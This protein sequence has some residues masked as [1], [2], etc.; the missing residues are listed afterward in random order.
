MFCGKLVYLIAIE[1]NTR[2]TYGEVTN[3]SIAGMEK[4]SVADTKKATSFLRAFQ[5]IIDQ[6]MN[7]KHLI[8]D[9]ESAFKSY[10]AKSYYADHGIEFHPVERQ[11]ENYIPKLMDTEIPEKRKRHLTTIQVYHSLTELLTQSE[12]WYINC[13]SD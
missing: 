2:F 9:G 12:T 10:L 4:F 8:G 1:V 13:K 3:M 7:V 5:R 11:K 6:G